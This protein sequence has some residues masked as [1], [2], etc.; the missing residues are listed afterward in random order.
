MRTLGRTFNLN[1]DNFFCEYLFI[2]WLKI[3][4]S[5]FMNADPNP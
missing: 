1:I 2:Y 5:L 4:V 3:Y